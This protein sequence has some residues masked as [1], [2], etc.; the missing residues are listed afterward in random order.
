MTVLSGLA[1][2]LVPSDADTA[3]LKTI[4]DIHPSLRFQ[5]H[6][7][8]A[9]LPPDIPHDLEHTLSSISQEFRV[10]FDTVEIGDHFFR[11]VYIA[12]HPSDE[13][14][15]LHRAVHTKL[16]IIN[17]RTPKYPHMSLCY[18]SDEDAPER[19]KYLQQL[20]SSGRIRQD[21]T[22]VSLN[23]REGDGSE[24]VWVSGFQ[25]AEL[26][27]VDCTGPVDSWT[28]KSKIAF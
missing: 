15:A 20:Q 21:G 5:P 8:V 27:L 10:S 12:V 26:W 22:S 1:L 7:T 11:S 17:P 6:I 2:W 24:D 28:P 18:I 14:L 16:G 19:T 13:M 23:S 25:A 4:M 3:K 9:S